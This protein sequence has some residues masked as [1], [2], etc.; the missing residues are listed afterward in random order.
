MYESFSQEVKNEICAVRTKQRCCRASLLYG[1]I[2][3]A[4]V[5]SPNAL[6]L[7]TE[8][9]SVA[10]QF[11]RLIREF[12]GC[13]KHPSDMSLTHLHDPTMITAVLTALGTTYEAGHPDPTVMTCQM[14]GW[15]FVKGVFLSCGTVTSPGNAYHLE[16]LISDEALA[17]AFVGFASTLGFMPKTTE[18]RGGQVGVYVK[19]SESVLDILGYFGANRAAFKL[20]DVKIYKDLRNNANRVANCETANIGKTVAAANEQMRAIESIIEAGAADKLP[21]E[22]R[23]TLDL[24][25][26]F[27]N[28]TLSEL[29]AMHQPPI[30]KSGVN[31]R[32]RRLVEFSKKY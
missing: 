7:D 8:N 1:M 20:L 17:E 4:T 6:M 22:L 9:P 16:F 30:T 21:D 23:Q 31:H 18:R 26:A 25:A 3:G 19:D 15:S 10:L 28:A 29:A 24:R 2:F 11:S 5:F 32:L 27:P 14:C 13:G 12:S